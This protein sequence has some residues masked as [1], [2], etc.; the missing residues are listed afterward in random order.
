MTYV[1]LKN[2]RPE[3]AASIRLMVRV[4]SFEE[5]DADRGIA[6]FLEHMA[7]NGTQTF[8]EGELIRRFAG[9]GIGFGRDQNAYTGPFSTVYS[10]DLNVADKD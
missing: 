2:A 1:I 10:L 7:F 9:A 8:P 6:H 3:G 4:G 5:S